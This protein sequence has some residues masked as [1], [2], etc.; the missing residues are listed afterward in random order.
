MQQADR[1][2]IPVL[3]KQYMSDICFL[4]EKVKNEKENKLM[5]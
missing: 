2:N 5:V 1:L 3:T 4:L